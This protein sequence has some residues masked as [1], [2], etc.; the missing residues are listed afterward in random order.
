MDDGRAVVVEAGD[1]IG[2]GWLGDDFQQAIIFASVN[3]PSHLP[4]HLQAR[5]LF[6]NHDSIQRLDSSGL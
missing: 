6:T 5:R 2:G 4:P 3:F 1:L